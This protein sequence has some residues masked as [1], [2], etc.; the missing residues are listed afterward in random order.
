MKNED[1]IKLDFELRAGED[2]K[3]YATNKEDLAKAENIYNEETHYGDFYGIVGT[4]SFLKKVNESLLNAEI[5]KEY[6]LEIP[7]EDAY[8]IRDPKNIKVH[9][10][11]E[12][13]RQN[14]DPVVGQEVIIDRKQGRIISVTPG[15]VMVDYNNKF[16]GKTIYYKYTVKEIISEPT[17]KVRALLFQNY[18]SSAQKFGITVE[19]ENIK[20]DI[21]EDSKFD[22]YWFD[23]KFRVVNEIR[24][25]LPDNNILLIESYPKQQKAEIA[26]EGTSQEPQPVPAE[27]TQAAETTSE[28]GPEKT[29]NE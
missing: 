10:V 9:T 7:P 24:K 1:F 14:I 4:E 13:Q 5:G 12:F 8:G 20:I 16:A 25:Y 21:P 26:P 3:L 2:K 27:G 22:H 19:G 11:R 28:A 23:V 29:A 18:S 17:E 6:E 15:R